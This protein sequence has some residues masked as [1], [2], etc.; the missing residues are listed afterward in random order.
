MKLLKK[1]FWIILIVIIIWMV[2]TNVFNLGRIWLG[3]AP[4]R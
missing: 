3:V 4:V 1:Y 2:K